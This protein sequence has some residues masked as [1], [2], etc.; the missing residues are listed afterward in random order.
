MQLERL[1]TARLG[2]TVLEASDLTV[3]AGGRTLLDRVTWQL[4][5]GERVGLIGPNGSG[6]STLLDLLAGPGGEATADPGVADPG[7]ADVGVAGGGGADRG[8]D[9]S[10]R[11]RPGQAAW[12]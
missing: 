9:R 8:A 7:L 10:G 1:A 3:T 12:R 5:P 6:K 2:K 11:C 4:G